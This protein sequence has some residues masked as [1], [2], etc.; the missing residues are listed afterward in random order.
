MKNK[1]FPVKMNLSSGGIPSARNQNF[2]IITSEKLQY[3][4]V[5]KTHQIGADREPLQ[6][7]RIIEESANMCLQMCSSG[8]GGIKS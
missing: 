7:A 8:N 4:H 3:F 6:L 5:R 1:F 2:L